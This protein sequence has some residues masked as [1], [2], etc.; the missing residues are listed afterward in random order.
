MELLFILPGESYC[1]IANQGSTCYLNSFIQSLFMNVDFRNEILNH[2][3]IG[4]VLYLLSVVY[5]NSL[6]ME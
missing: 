4:D 6:L 5:L 1:G 3:G 2:P